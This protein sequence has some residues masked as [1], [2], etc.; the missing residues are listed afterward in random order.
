MVGQ[1]QNVRPEIFWFWAWMSCQFL[2]AFGLFCRVCLAEVY[3][4]KALIGDFMNR[5]RDYE[6]PKVG[7]VRWLGSACSRFWSGTM[8]LTVLL[9]FLQTDFFLLVWEIDLLVL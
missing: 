3:Q 2:P 7:H 4:D 5:K 6:D 1:S 9:L 8:G